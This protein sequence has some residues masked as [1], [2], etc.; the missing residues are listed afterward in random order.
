[1]QVDG[2]KWNTISQSHIHRKTIKKLHY[3]V[4]A[5]LPPHTHTR[6]GVMLYLSNKPIRIYVFVNV[7][8]ANAQIFT[9][10]SWTG[11][12]TVGT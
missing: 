8:V 12:T 3:T 6:M 7:R 5:R 2:N 11:L 4:E 10:I 1:M 9:L